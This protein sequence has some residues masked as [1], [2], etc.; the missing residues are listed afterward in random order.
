MSVPISKIM[1][2]IDGTEG[3]IAA[4]QYAVALSRSTGAELCAL[5]VVNMRAL[6]DLLR[7]RIF[8]KDEQ[9]DY[10]RDLE[11]DADRYLNHVR[12]LA[13]EKGVSIDTLKT[14]GAVNQEIKN[15]ITEREIDLLVLGELAHI[16]SRRDA[17]YDEAERAMRSVS[18]SVLI[19][20]D[21]ER[22]QE[23]YDTL[24]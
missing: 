3:S 1:V 23:M 24:E 4:A 17:F 10:Q 16:R 9:E 19:V 13:R 12:E 2:Y 5:Y 22:V 8:L 20:K 14:S 6:D 7:S 21:E 11:A 15:L 18:C